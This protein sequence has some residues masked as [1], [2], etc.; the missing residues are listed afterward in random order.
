VK[1][2]SETKSVLELVEEVVDENGPAICSYNLYTNRRAGY[3]KH[4]P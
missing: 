1:P 3:T 2:E 4:H